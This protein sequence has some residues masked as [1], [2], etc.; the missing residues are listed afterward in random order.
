M[1]SRPTARRCCRCCRGPAF[2]RP[3]ASVVGRAS[4]LSG[5]AQWRDSAGR[6]AV[7]AAAAPA[8]P[9]P[10]SFPA[11][12]SCACLSSLFSPSDLTLVCRLNARVVSR[13]VR[14]C[15]TGGRHV[16]RMQPGERGAGRICRPCAGRNDAPT[17][18]GEPTWEPPARRPPPLQSVAR[19]ASGGASF[20]K[21]PPAGDFRGGDPGDDPLALV[22]LGPKWPVAG[23]S[24]ASV[25]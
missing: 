21:G 12:T 13:Q 16:Y 19:S 8:A 1:S 10:L 2:I 6:R 18:L 7:A 22:S 14:R 11:L 25:G 4:G 3:P 9:R 20:F 5:R 23:S 24:G 15:R 17:P